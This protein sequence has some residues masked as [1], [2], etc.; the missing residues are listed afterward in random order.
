MA[1]AAVIGG[2]LA[3]LLAARVL[4]D[5][6][7][8]VTVVERDHYPDQA[9]YR[10]GV[11]Q[12][13]HLHLLLA[14]GHEILAQ[15]FPTLDE[16]F[17]QLNI[18]NLD[19][20]MDSVAYTAGGWTRRVRTGIISNPVSR[21][22]IDWYVRGQ[23]QQR[24][25]IHFMTGMDVQRLIASADN[26]VITGIEAKSRDDQSIQTI[27]ADLVVDASGRSSKAPDWLQTLGYSAPPRTTV[28]SHLGY[29][30]RWYE[31]PT[32]REYDWHILLVTPLPNEGNYRGGGIQQVEGDKWVVTLAGIN[33]VFPP[34]DAEGFLE[35]ARQL[36]SSALYEAIKDAAPITPVYGYRRTENIWNHYEQLDRHPQHFAVIGDAYC[37]FNPVYGQGMSVAA[38]E[39][40]ALDHLLRQNGASS[41]DPAAFY[42]ALANTIRNPWLMATGED[43]RY[44]GTEGDRPGLMGRLVQKYIE[45]VLAVLP[46][47][48]EIGTA[49]VKVNN[50][51]EPP[52]SLMHP[53]LMARVLA[54]TLRGVQRD[55]E[56]NKPVP[57][58]KEP[59][60]GD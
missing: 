5:H 14:K 44:P 6:F 30:T 55:D 25:N 49:F 29:A 38:M 17:K 37:G 53:R 1:H 19:I 26:T 46:L 43:L 28:N 24:P 11:P 10:N 23:L 50:L 42:K 34:T 21:V 35:F 22:T 4:S 41:F 45:R 33:K 59:I 39:A 31:R 27:N 58:M 36:P 56:L 40:Q 12:A 52:Q 51:I 16:D 13:R 57:K 9:D 15:F 54:H 60:S 8:R 7:E 18:P 48:T 3:G 2:S 32:D 20:G 47:D